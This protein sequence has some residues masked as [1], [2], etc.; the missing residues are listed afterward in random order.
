VVNSIE[1]YFNK[2]GI[3]VVMKL[4]KPAALILIFVI[5]VVLTGC[6]EK[7]T[8]AVNNFASCL[9]EKGA[10]MYGAHWCGHCKEQKKL[11]GSSFAKVD[12]IECTVETQRCENEGVK[13]YPTWKFADGSSI[14]GVQTFPTLAQKT[15]CFLP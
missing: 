1:N 7:N 14:S 8:E 3:V 9:S 10:K 6:G 12:Y 2:K 11:F 5:S 4:I 15:G 13:G